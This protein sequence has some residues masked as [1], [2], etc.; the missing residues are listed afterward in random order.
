MGLLAAILKLIMMM[1]QAVRLIGLQR[2]PRLLCYLWY[3][4]TLLQCQPHAELTLLAAHHH[5]EHL[6]SLSLS[7]TLTAVLDNDTG[8]TLLA[9]A[10]QLS[11]TA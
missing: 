8:L 11:G 1:S 6:A 7:G 3:R 5:M 9:W 4:L 2:L 10:Q